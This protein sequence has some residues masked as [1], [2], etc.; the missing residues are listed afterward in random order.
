ML[1]L[2]N[3]PMTARFSV[4]LVRT[5]LKTYHADITATAANLKMKRFSDALS[6]VWHFCIT[7]YV[8]FH[9]LLVHSGLFSAMVAL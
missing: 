3:N 7:V 1:K 8:L 6:K 9:S 4:S 2:V 5:I